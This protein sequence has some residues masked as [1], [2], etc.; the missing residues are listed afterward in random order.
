MKLGGEELTNGIKQRASTLRIRTYVMTISI[1]VCLVFW[2]F[3]N[4]T[5]KEAISWV[6]FVLLTVVQ[7]LIYSS[8][9][10]DGELFG[11]TDSVYINNRSAYNEKASSI[12]SNHQIGLLR[13]YCKVDFERRIQIY[14]ENECGVLGITLEEL[15]QLK[16]LD[17]KEIK[18]LKTFTF[19][20]EIGKDEFEEKVVKFSRHKRKRLYNL[21]F[22]PLP[23]EENHAETI[24]SAV[25][26]DG[27]KSIKDTSV[28]FKVRSYL[29]KVIKAV[30]IGAVLAY[31]GFTARDGIGVAEIARICVYLATI[32]S[33]AVVAY[34]AGETCTKVYKSRFY[35]DLA[36][37]IDGFNEWVLTTHTIEE[38]LV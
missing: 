10:P 28:T 21:I 23:I 36:N 17:E 2:L 12:N 27:H 11:T 19:K 25:E 4:I 5:T 16:S 38:R 35:V 9:F 22:K 14:I 13:D 24:M 30:T 32:I 31:I 34:S 3:V 18:K 26:N 29:G 37:F 6:D 8:Y 7:V 20:Y 1:L 15:E 33:N